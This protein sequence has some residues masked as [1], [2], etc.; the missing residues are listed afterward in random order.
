MIK[1]SWFTVQKIDDNTF[2]ISEYG[3]WEKVHS[4]LLLGREKAILIDT[5]LGID[6]IKRITDQL[7]HV[8][9]DVNT[10]HVH[11]DHIGS[12]RES[13][14]IYVHKAEKYWLVNGIKGLSIQPIREGMSRY[15]TWP[16]PDTLNPQT[17]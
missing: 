3:H 15:I 7:T 1:D 2:A 8:H 6:N 16:T 12:H 17:Y 14:R 10:T 11:V 5:G 13:E 4:F 9:I